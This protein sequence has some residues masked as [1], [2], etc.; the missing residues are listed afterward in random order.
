MNV[1]NT[2]IFIGFLLQSRPHPEERR[3]A[4]R[5]EGWARAHCLLPILRDGA[6]RLLRMRWLVALRRRLRAHAAVDLL[7]RRAVAGERRAAHVARLVGREGAGAVHGLAV[8]P[9][10]K[11]A[12]P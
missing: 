11:I 12:Q 4:A 1:A 7:R 5:L 8:V 6:A 10:D 3:V 2:P 9:H